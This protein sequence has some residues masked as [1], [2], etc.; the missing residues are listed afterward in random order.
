MAIQ[1]STVLRNNRLD[2][3]ESGGAQGAPTSIVAWQASHAYT[4]LT[5]WCINDTGKMYLCTTSGTSASSGGPTGTGANITDGTAHWTY[6]GQAGIEG[7]PV[8]SL[9]DGTMPANCAASLSG[10][11]LL[12]TGSLPADWM[13]NASSGS[14]AKNGTWTV[15]GQSGA[16][17]G[18]NVTFFRIYD[19]AGTCHIQGSVTAT[20]GG[21]VMTMDNV[22]VANAQVVTVNTFSLTD[23]NA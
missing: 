7:T 20:G 19:L 17:T 14:K 4:A 6:I 12:A 13:S 10:N 23:G 11:T 5:D 22:N 3:I 15:T 8:L 2:A 16:S 18:T 21:G 1:Y 9:Y